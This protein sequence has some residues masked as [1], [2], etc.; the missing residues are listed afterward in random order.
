MKNI[1]KNTKTVVKL[2]VNL[3]ERANKSVNYGP[4]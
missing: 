2:F 1:K 4:M 3:L